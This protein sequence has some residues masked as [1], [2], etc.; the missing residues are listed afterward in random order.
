MV[1]QSGEN[2]VAALEIH[3]FP[4]LDDNYGYLIRDRET[5][6]TAA[7]DTP[8]AAAIR[9]A[10]DRKGWRLDF[11]W[12][13][14]HHGDHAGGNLALKAATGCRIIGPRADVARI[15]GIDDAVGDGD[16]VMLGS[17]KARVFDTPGHTRGHIVYVF[18]EDRAIFTG[19]TL[20]AMGCGRLFEGTPDQMWHSLQKLLALPDEMR[21][22]CAHEYTQKNAH[23]ALTL[24]PGNAALAARVGEV[25]RMRANG[26]PTVPST[27]GRERATNPF[28][29]PD[30]AA[31]QSALGLSGAPLTAV[32]AEIR[33]RRNVY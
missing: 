24:E 10:L 17:R 19:D 18:D 16:T 25:D 15:P 28:L 29:R 20:F 1:M 3:Q 14:H 22:Y 33:Q 31:L 6:A 27:I 8:D 4:C 12:N 26:L 32:F 5:G 30:S 11:I 9:A 13:T 7:I 21:V 23:F 2:A